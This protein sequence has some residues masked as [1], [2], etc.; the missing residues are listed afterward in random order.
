MNNKPVDQIIVPPKTVQKIVPII[1]KA[2]KRIKAE[3]ASKEV[4]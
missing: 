2:L 1:Y 3:E 4:S